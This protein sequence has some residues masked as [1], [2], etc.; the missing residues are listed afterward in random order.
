MSRRCVEKLCLFCQKVIKEKNYRC[1]FGDSIVHY[2]SQIH[3]I[4]NLP[5]DKQIWARKGLSVYICMLCFTKLNR[6]CRIEVDLTTK[7]QRLRE[8]K[9]ALIKILGSSFKGPLGLEHARQPTDKCVT[10]LKV[11]QVSSA[12]VSNSVNVTPT[13]SKLGL[14]SGG[15]K[16]L[17]VSTPSPKKPVKRP[18]LKSPRKYA[19][20]TPA[21]AQVASR[22]PAPALSVSTGVSGDDGCAPP[23]QKHD[24]QTQAGSPL[25]PL[26][27]VKVRLFSKRP[28]I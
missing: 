13:K 20:I 16:R 5:V 8:E 21:P 22:D 19:P 15:V 24:K 18:V 14:G 7:L 6:L 25:D 10:P 11:K 9:D 17:L 4:V 26:G 27:T 2:H 23:K 1:V 28:T 12:P 3:D